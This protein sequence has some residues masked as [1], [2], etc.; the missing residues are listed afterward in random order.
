MIR[1]IPERFSHKVNLKKMNVNQECK[2]KK[3]AHKILRSSL[4]KKVNHVKAYSR[5]VSCITIT[6]K[7]FAF[8]KYVYSVF[9]MFCHLLVSFFC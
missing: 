2:N 6:P 4:R 3:K 7:K 5:I 9:L 1:T 8:L